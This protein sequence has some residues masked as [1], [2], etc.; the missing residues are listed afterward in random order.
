MEPRVAVL[1]PIWI[2]LSIL[3]GGCLKSRA[4]LDGARE[5]PSG[6]LAFES[7]LKDLEARNLNSQKCD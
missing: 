7:L 4:D 5:S 6:F 3:C 2:Q 1:P